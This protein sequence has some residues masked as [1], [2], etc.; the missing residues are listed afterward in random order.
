VPGLAPFA[1]GQAQAVPG[2]MP[3]PGFAPSVVPGLSGPD[4]TGQYRA[5][6]KPQAVPGLTGEADPFNMPVNPGVQSKPLSEMPEPF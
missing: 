5:P 1:P 6:V 4:T 3:A 2:L